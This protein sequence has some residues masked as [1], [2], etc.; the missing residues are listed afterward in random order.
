MYLNKL[1][2]NKA[3]QKKF[4]KLI[5]VVLLLILGYNNQ[6]FISEIN[7]YYEDTF[8][9]EIFQQNIYYNLQEISD[10]KIEVLFCPSNECYEIF[11]TSFDNAKFEIK[12]AFYELD[13]LNLSEILSEKSEDDVEISLIIDNDYLLEDSIKELSNTKVKVY[14]DVNRGTRYN[15]YMHDKF[16]IIDDEILITG[17]TNPTTNGFFKNN[18]NLIVLNSKSLATNYENEFD[19]MSNNVF[20]DNKKSFLEFNNITIIENENKYIISSYMCPQDNC[21]DEI[22]DILNSAKEEI[23]F[24]TFAIT[25]NDISNK[26]IGKSI[27]G[28]NVSGLI[29]KRNFNLKGSDAK[30]L[31]SYFTLYNDTSKGNMHHKFF[32]VDERI[33][34][35]GS[36]NPS[37]SGDDYNDENVLIIENE[38]IAKLYKEEYLRLIG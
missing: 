38:R 19:Q 37:A 1:S 34:I 3:M 31:S 9:D 5:I 22:I 36:M 32:V 29:E 35:T 12:C 20:G 7:Y 23:F 4:L 2:F 8:E 25:H 30:N 24:A 15:N 28:L 11:E 27:E 6:S 26:L 17:S 13:E 10:E 21:G 33:V 18:N 16:C 14:S